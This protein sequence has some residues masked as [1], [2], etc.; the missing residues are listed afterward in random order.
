MM[1]KSSRIIVYSKR[2]SLSTFTWSKTLA[3]PKS[4]KYPR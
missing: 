2:L 1:R 3:Y 4:E